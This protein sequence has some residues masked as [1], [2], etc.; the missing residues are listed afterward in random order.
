MI[1]TGLRIQALHITNSSDFT[2]SKGY[3]GLLS[4]LGGLLGVMTCCVPS[5]L[6][7]AQC[8]PIQTLKRHWVLSTTYL[9]T[10]FPDAFALRR[11]AVAFRRSTFALRGSTVAFRRS[12]WQY[13]FRGRNS[14]SGTQRTERVDQFQRLADDD[15][16]VKAESDCT[17]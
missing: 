6:T 2:Y 16:P 4:V 11:F 1:I 12:T 17:V 7:V 15:K 5:L 13:C 14:C 3:I 9:K 10:R 8:S